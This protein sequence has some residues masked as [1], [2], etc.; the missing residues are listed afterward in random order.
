MIPDDVLFK[1]GSEFIDFQ[2]EIEK[3][4]SCPTGFKK[5]PLNPVKRCRDRYKM[6]INGTL[7]LE[8]P[9]SKFPKST[10]NPEEYCFDLNH[11]ASHKYHHF[12]VICQNQHDTIKEEMK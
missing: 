8:Y 9:S 10:F 12:P 11:E 1:K 5:F 7:V 6:E 3:K 2:P 4:E